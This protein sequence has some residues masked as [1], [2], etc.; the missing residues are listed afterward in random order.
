[1]KL[2]CKHCSNEFEIEDNRIDTYYDFE[3]D[4]NTDNPNYWKNLE[5]TNAIMNTYRGLFERIGFKVNSV[6]NLEIIK[7]VYCPN[8]EYFY[9]NNEL[10]KILSERCIFLLDELINKVDLTQRI[11]KAAIEYFKEKQNEIDRE[12]R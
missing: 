5:M 6:K 12:S 7:G 8:C 2:T 9:T 10:I 1:M 4:I 11:R 3:F